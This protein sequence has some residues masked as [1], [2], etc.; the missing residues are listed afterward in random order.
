MP[1]ARLGLE[2]ALGAALLLLAAGIGLRSTPPQLLLW[3]GTVL[4]GV[5]IA[6]LNVLLPWPGTVKRLAP[7]SGIWAGLALVAVGVLAPQLLTRPRDPSP[8]PPAPRRSRAPWTT[9]HRFTSGPAWR[10]DDTVNSL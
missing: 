7:V 3:A 1:T 10:H 4:L 5:A 9:S 6:I 2:R 8:S